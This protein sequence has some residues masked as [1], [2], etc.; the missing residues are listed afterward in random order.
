MAAAYGEREVEFL[1]FLEPLFL[2]LREEIVD[3]FLGAFGRERVC[4]ASVELAV[5]AQYRR[6][7]GADQ[8]VRG[9]FLCDKIEEIM[10]VHERSFV[11]LNRDRGLASS[12]ER[13]NH[14]RGVA[15]MQCGGRWASVML[16]D[17]QLPLHIHERIDP[18]TI[19]EAA[20]K[21]PPLPQGEG[22]GEGQRQLSRK[23]RCP[24]S[25]RQRVGVRGSYSSPSSNRQKKT[26]RWRAAEYSERIAIECPRTLWCWGRSLWYAG[27]RLVV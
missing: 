23:E 19:I 6:R 18:G 9:F 1:L 4:A 26:R 24:L 27:F 11:A 21:V 25:R 16:W 10:D 2:F 14:N 7:P 3:E 5:Y 22:W 12:F 13:P 17:S 8:Q 20:R 15:R